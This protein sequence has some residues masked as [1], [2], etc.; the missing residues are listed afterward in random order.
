M[1]TNQTGKRFYQVKIKGLDITSIK[2]LGRLMGPLQ[3]QAFRK[4][5]GKILDWTIA[6][7]STEAIVSLT[8]YYDQPLRCFTFGD[9]QLVPTVEEFEEI[10]GCPL[11]GRKP[12]LFSECLPSLSKIAVVVKDSARELDRVKQTRNGVVGLPRKYLEGKARDMANQEKWVPFMDVL[13]LL[14]FGVV[15]FPNMD[16][17]VDLAA[18][19][20]F[21]AYHQSKESPMIAILTNLFDTF[22]RR[23]EKSSARI[24]C[25]L[26]ALYV[27]LVSHLF[28]QDIR[29]PCPLR[30]HRSCVK[31][32]RVDWDQLLDGIGDRTISWF[33]RWKEGMEGVLFSCGEYPNI[34]LIGTRGCINNNPALAIRQLGYR[35]RGAPTEESLSPFL[36]R[37]FSVQSFKIIQ[38]VHKAWESPL[39][40]DKELR[41]IRNGIIGGY[42]EWLK[43]RTR[44]LDW[45]SKLKIIDEESF[46]A[47]EEGEEARALKT[48]LG[49]A[50]LDKEKF[51]RPERV[52]RL[53]EENAATARALEQETKRARKEEHGRDKFCGALWGS[54]SELKLRREER[55]QSRAHSMVLK[56][57]LATCSRSKRSLSQRLCE[58]E[59]NML[60]IVS[61]YQEELNLATA[62]EHKVA[63]DY[64]RVYAEK[65]ARG[66]VI[67]SLHQEA[68]MWMDRFAL[69]LNG[70]QELPRL[71]AKAKAMADTYSAPE[72]IHGLLSY[73]Q[74]M[75]DL[76]AHIIRNR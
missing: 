59:T 25:F 72:E 41:G 49:K 46:E 19:D 27:W 52:C 35:M 30:S 34:P 22:D 10:L 66:R 74:H 60:A 47:P 12:Y 48:E 44:G 11:G 21:L 4:A 67:D 61:K 18:I 5:Y 53:R 31:K 71:L 3:M 16:G 8:Q 65:E 38:T 26:P 56:E 43:V 62:H 14:I 9:F 1:G 50:R 40:K 73:C 57:E 69:T 32:R 58:T 76:M 63:D 36:V 42:H 15:L 68:T 17:L 28:Q 64:A 55:Y 54:N 70:S 2:K 20:A 24:I 7:I 39:R 23:C 75:I 37:D 45:L 29:H 6:E 13:A 33:P 51:K